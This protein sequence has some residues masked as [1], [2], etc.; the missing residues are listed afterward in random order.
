MDS[1]DIPFVS[2]IIF[3]TQISCKNMRKAKEAKMKPPPNLPAKKGK[4]A[5]ISAAK[6]QCVE[7][8]KAFP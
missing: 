8:P 3:H 4:K 6:T 1:N 5:D 7:L 2:G